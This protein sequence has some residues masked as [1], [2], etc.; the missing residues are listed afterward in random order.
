M[1]VFE[2]ISIRKF[3][4]RTLLIC[5]L[6]GSSLY[7]NNPIQGS[8]LFWQ[9]L[10]VHLI[11]HSSNLASSFEY[12][13][14]LLNW[15]PNS[16]NNQNTNSQNS[17][18]EVD[19]DIL[20][21]MVTEVFLSG[22][23]IQQQSFI[24]T[25][26]QTNANTIISPPPSFSNSL[27]LETILDSEIYFENGS[28]VSTRANR[29]SATTRINLSISEFI[30]LYTDLAQATHLSALNGPANQSLIEMILTQM[31]HSPYRIS[32]ASFLDAC[33]EIHYRLMMISRFSVL[34]DAT[35]YNSIDDDSFVLNSQW[36]S[37]PV[38]FKDGKKWKEQHN[39]AFKVKNPSKAYSAIT[40]CYQGEQTLDCSGAV[41]THMYGSLALTLGEDA[42]NSLVQ[43]N[44]NILI[45]STMNA[46]FRF[47]KTQGKGLGERVGPPLIHFGLIDEVE[48]EGLEEILPGDVVYFV[49][50]PNYEEFHPQGYYAGEWCVYLGVGSNGQPLFAGLGM[51]PQSFASVIQTLKR[52]YEDDLGQKFPE[53]ESFEEEDIDGIIGDHFPSLD[54][55]IYSMRNFRSGKKF[56]SSFKE[57]PIK[58]T[59]K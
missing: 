23:P 31:M 59:K 42:F 53:D 46:N 56:S 26:S 37:I 14:D 47:P 39:A 2:M 10:I 36:T 7:A 21:D 48:M 15:H 51:P 3:L 5:S 38:Y 12:I 29:R 55:T 34:T 22:Q 32:F 44:P 18:S 25:Q 27:S 17:L 49:N 8:N 35:S 58:K 24:A 41:I 19:L 13:H 54:T 16:N 20:E 1:K 6:S 43:K 28:I 52:A 50:H 33:M 11:G 57:T 4:V 9:F 30:R 40:S 45:L